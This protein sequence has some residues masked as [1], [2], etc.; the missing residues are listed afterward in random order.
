MGDYGDVY[1]RKDA[2]G[3]PGRT[4]AQN[5]ATVQQLKLVSKNYALCALYGLRNPGCTTFLY[6]RYWG[7]GM[8]FFPCGLDCR[9]ELDLHADQFRTLNLARLLLP[10]VTMYLMSTLKTL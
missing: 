4:K 8:V 2:A 5:R 6:G 9:V 10:F 1:M 3:P 7:P